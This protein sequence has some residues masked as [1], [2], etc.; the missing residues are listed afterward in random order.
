MSTPAS[1]SPLHAG[2]AW[3]RLEAGLLRI[4]GKDAIAFLQTKLTCDTRL[5]RRDGG[6]YGFA[7]NINGKIQLEGHFYLDQSEVLAVLPAEQVA[8]AV[9]HLDRWVIREDV[10]FADESATSFVLMLVGDAAVTAARAA[11]N[12]QGDED[13]GWLQSDGIRLARLQAFP[14][15]GALLCGP[16]AQ[17]DVVTAKLTAAGAVEATREE[18]DAYEVIVGIPRTPTELRVDETIPLE[19]GAFWGVSFNK[20]C[21]LGQEIIERLY[22]RGQPARRILQFRWRG[23]VV[24][25]GT[26]VRVGDDEVGSVTRCVSDGDQAVALAWIKRKHLPAADADAPDYRLGDHAAEYVVLV[27]GDG[28]RSGVV[29]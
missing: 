22:S 20:G 17:Y 5:W 16:L 24:A 27:G 1:N 10:V 13:A 2:N 26:P 4:G 11:L 12:L 21:Y 23:D 25:P 19:A 3:V 6:R 9:T 15:T 29:A 14:L 8:G 28:P 18:L 7:V